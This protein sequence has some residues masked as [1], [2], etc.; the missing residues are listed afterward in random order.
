MTKTQ[1][2]Y[3]ITTILEDKVN[4]YTKLDKCKYITMSKP[5]NIYCGKDTLLVYFDMDNE[6]LI[7]Y[8]CRK[9]NNIPSTGITIQINNENYQILTDEN[10]NALST[11]YPFSEIIIFKLAV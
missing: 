5:E 10:S 6:L 11:H 2:N 8:P 3:I 1:V 7:T 4:S 9:V